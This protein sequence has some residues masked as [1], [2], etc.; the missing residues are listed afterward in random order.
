MVRLT[1]LI[2]VAICAAGLV[3]WSESPTAPVVAPAAFGPRP[4]AEG[5]KE[6]VL[7]TL[8]AVGGNRT[9]AAALLGIGRNTLNR[10]LAGWGS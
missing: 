6:H 3:A 8:A 5:E 1:I 10:K 4:I 9:R 7:A 2:G